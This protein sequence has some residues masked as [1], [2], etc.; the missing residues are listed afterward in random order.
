MVRVRCAICSPARIRLDSLHSVNARS[1]R[2]EDAC[3]Q[4]VYAMRPQTR[5]CSPRRVRAAGRD[6]GAHETD[7]SGTHTARRARLSRTCVH[8]EAPFFDD[9][10]G[11]I[12][13]EAR[14]R[15]R[16]RSSSPYRQPR[17]RSFWSPE[18]RRLITHKSFPK[19]ISQSKICHINDIAVEDIYLYIY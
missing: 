17:A 15:K 13:D 16:A 6:R 7:E 1:T 19:K 2:G 14:N 9:G 12:G 18:T 10:I 3:G 11:C 5:S 8:V 4:R